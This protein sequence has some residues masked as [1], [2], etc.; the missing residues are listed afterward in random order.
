MK[1]S[2]SDGDLLVGQ[3]GAVDR[4]A[5]PGLA[6]ARGGEQAGDR[7]GHRAGVEAPGVEGLAPPS[8]LALEHLVRLVGVEVRARRGDAVHH[9]PHREHAEGRR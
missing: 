2:T 6:L 8:L 5:D 4:V 7:L 1:R 9:E 3:L